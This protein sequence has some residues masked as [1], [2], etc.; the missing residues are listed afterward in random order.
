MHQINRKSM[1][2][3]KILS[4]VCGIL[5]AAL[6]MTACNQ[7]TGTIQTSEDEPSASTASGIRSSVNQSSAISS[8]EDV[9]TSSDPA[10]GPSSYVASSA[11]SSVSASGSSSVSSSSSKSASSSSANSQVFDDVTIYPVTYPADR[12]KK[13]GDLG[14]S[15]S[16]YKNKTRQPASYEGNAGWGAISK[17]NAYFN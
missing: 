7:P 6:M 4:T 15:E 13:I 10:S 14:I 8:N 3:G 5:A 2:S 17:T 11:A 9:S 1:K 12:V 16:A